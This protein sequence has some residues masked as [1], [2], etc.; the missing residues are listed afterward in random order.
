MLEL[1][2]K[3]AIFH[4]NKKSLED[5]TVPMW[6]VK[7]K[8][9]TYYVNHVTSMIPW[10]T[11]ETPDNNHTKGAIKVKNVLIQIDDDNCATFKEL[12]A[13]D[14]IRI[15]TKN[16]VRIL[17]TWK[18][19]VVSFMDDHAIKYTKLKTIHGSCGSVFWVC[20]I[21]NP[22]DAVM[23]QLGDT[24]GY[25]RVLQ[26]NEKYYQAYDDEKLRSTLDADDY[27]NDDENDD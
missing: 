9:K 13:Q 16:Y 24:R 5:K 4:F 25:Y 22:D 7:S 2:C 8:G 12:T 3:E 20:D 10:S 26:E 1:A 15:K 17:I 21:K 14:K 19:R 23:M 6:V 27:Y 11:K 18:E